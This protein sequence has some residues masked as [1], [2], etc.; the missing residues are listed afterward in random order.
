MCMQRKENM[1]TRYVV[2]VTR[3]VVQERIRMGDLSKSV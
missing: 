1:V 3:Y 2:M